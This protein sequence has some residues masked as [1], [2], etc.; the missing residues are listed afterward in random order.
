VVKLAAA[1]WVSIALAAGFLAPAS[2]ADDGNVGL[3]EV[4]PR[5]EAA[6]RA[7]LDYLASKQ[8]VDPKDP[9]QGYW[10][11]MIGRKVNDEYRGHMGR[12]VGV[13]ALAC[14]AFLSNGSTPGRGP[15]G[16]Q[17]AR[18]LN[19]LLARV[20]K[21]DGFITADESRMYEHAFATLFLAEVYGMTADDRIRPK[22]QQAV[23]CIVRAQNHYGGWR[24]LPGSKDSDMSITV[25]QVQALR[26]AR[27]VGIYV[28][29]GTID[30]A[31]AYVKASFID[32]TYPNP[33]YRGG[34]WYQVIDQ[35][36][37]S[38]R[39]SFPLTAA[40]VTALYGA[41]EYDSREVEEGLKFLF[42]PRWRPPEW[43]AQSSFDYYY[44]HYYAAQAFYQ[45]G[46]AYWREWYPDIR[47][48][49]L[50]WQHQEGYWQ[51]LVGRNYAT[52]MA[53]IILQLP[54]RYLPILER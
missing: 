12:H 40:G 37:R 9:E 15:Y 6:I 48:E 10:V 7:G 3:V 53:C 32:E 51:D 17:V 54:Y 29:R 49:M 14:M 38:S 22:L 5:A 44:G 2:R 28:P 39:T 52:A 18:G 21:D 45:A 24:Y 41:G 19:F 36:F 26:A 23:D 47:E 13:T 31:I 4:T 20:N 33:A 35:P 30:A 1:T 50:K 25:C 27:N 43:R 46:G 8:V 42:H 11:E 16:E 34:F